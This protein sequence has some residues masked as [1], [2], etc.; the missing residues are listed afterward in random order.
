MKTIEQNEQN[1]VVMEKML[2]LMK[3]ECGNKSLILSEITAKL[4]I[5]TQQL[6]QALEENEK[7]R[8]DLLSVKGESKTG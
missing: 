2:H 6:T 5:K 4:E 3:T 8:A 1:V 7:M